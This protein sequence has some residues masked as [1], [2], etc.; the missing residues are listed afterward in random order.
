MENKQLRETDISETLVTKDILERIYQLKSDLVEQDRKRMDRLREMEILV[1]KEAKLQERENIIQ[2][3]RT[4][5]EIAS[6]SMISSIEDILCDLQGERPD[7]LYTR[8]R[9]ED[10]M[11]VFF[12]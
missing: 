9:G 10:D 1:T 2:K 11:K 4:E 6:T 5:D 7:S 12:T 3:V 8:D